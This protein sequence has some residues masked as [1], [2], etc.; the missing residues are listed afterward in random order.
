MAKA[1]RGWGAI[2]L[3]G[4]AAVAITGTAQA[5]PEGELRFEA[6][7]RGARALV[8]DEVRWEFSILPA[9]GTKPDAA[10]MPAPIRVGDAV[11]FCGEGQLYEANPADGVIRR[12]LRLPGRCAGV[13]ARGEGY[14]VRC[15]G[16]TSSAA[17]WSEVYRV[18]LGEGEAGSALP[19][20]FLLFTP[21]RQ[22]EEL[23][24]KD[25]QASLAALDRRRAIDP[26]NPW[27]DLKR[28]EVLQR[29]GRA[30][31]S[32]QA[33]SDALGHDPRYDL[34]LIM[35]AGRLD[36]LDQARADE[37]FRRGMAYLLGHGYE[38]ELATSVLVPT[39][40][41]GRPND[42]SGSAA[43][44]PLL[45]FAKDHAVLERHAA[46]LVDL[47][48]NAE[49][50][51][52]FFAALA[53]AAAKR[54]DQAAV[55][56]WRPLGQRVEGTSLFA[57][58]T[59]ETRHLGALVQAV[60]ALSAS[61]VGLALIKTIQGLR[62]RHKEGT[63]GWVRRN[64]FARWGRP[65]LVGF[66][67][68]VGVLIGLARR[69]ALGVSMVGAMAAA[70]TS[71]LAGNLAHPEAQAFLAQVATSVEHAEP[72][73]V[74]IPFVRALA[75]QIA[76]DLAGAEA[77]Y[78]E[79]SGASLPASKSNLGA[80]AA[81][82]GDSAQARQL[83]QEALALDPQQDAARA[84]LGLPDAGPRAERRRR[85][86]V[87]R[88]LLALP[89]PLLWGGF[90][91]EKVD[92]S[93]LTLN[94]LSLLQMV[95]AVTPDNSATDESRAAVLVALLLSIPALLALVTWRPLVE[96]RPSWRRVNAALGVLFPGASWI[97]GPLGFLLGGAAVFV[98]FGSYIS[99]ESHGQAVTVIDWLI[100]PAWGRYYGVQETILPPST[101][102]AVVRSGGLLFV[103][104]SA[105][106][107]AAEW[108]GLRQQAPRA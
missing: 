81:S 100:A 15:Q 18:K 104:N 92:V 54:G 94:P 50:S 108:R 89:R 103:F 10:P 34:E 49:G 99:L 19:E 91:R 31:E 25:P 83:W 42:S 48:P 23:V 1:W 53:E 12:R 72:R 43:Q 14:E 37:A 26:T 8:G 16:S 75:R 7:T 39:I 106:A 64:P 86:G 56:R 98:A 3:G 107:L 74:A 9:H 41:L 36:L 76:G 93:P 61:L 21:R 11:V 95:S 27:L 20:T 62:W 60:M 80:I 45:D 58:G 102:V 97:Y 55:A 38:P 4:V 85:F 87:S 73:P 51:T 63:P 29:L 22:A 90:W 82:R 5:A 35:M 6:T 2:A 33:V 69:A 24:G 30:D 40:L 57:P 13:E 70:P 88:P 101:L 78:R 32:Q 66:L 84:G 17:P 77:I 28:A 105:L 65:E 68:G 96:A 46:R 79:A 44:A 59:A 52:W 67:L 47:A 71:L